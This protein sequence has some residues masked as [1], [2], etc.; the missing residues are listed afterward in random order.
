VIL[1]KG[2]AQFINALGPGMRVGV[3]LFRGFA[4]AVNGLLTATGNTIGWLDN[5]L[6]INLHS[7]AQDFDTARHAIASAWDAL[8]RD[9]I[10]VAVTNIVG[11]GSNLKRWYDYTVGIFTSLYH[12]GLT[13][14]NN[15]WA[16]IKT[17]TTTGINAV[18]GFF[19]AMPGKVTSALGSLG[20]DLKNLGSAATHELLSGITSVATSILNWFKSFGSSI[21]S[22]FKKV[23][24]IFSPSSVFHSIGVSIA[25]GLAN[26]I[27]AGVSKHV[28][29]AMGGLH[30][31]VHGSGATAQAYAQSI[32][33]RFGWAGQWPALNAVAMAE[34]GWSLTARNPSS[35]AYGIAQFINGPG[36]YYQYGGNPNTVAGQVTA[37]FNYIRQRYGSPD[38]AWAHES[39]Y[40]WYGQGLQNG[41]FSKPTIIGVGESGPEMVNITPMRS[42][43]ANYAATSGDTYVLNVTAPPLTDPDEVYRT[44]WKGLRDL[45]RHRKMDLGLT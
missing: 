5:R 12:S 44:V 10:G 23:L 13:I 14:W 45:K 35:G 9:V 25:H 6:S 18:T 22:A 42:R 11:I 1:V 15:T 7:W 20:T 24:G 26:G 37:F 29:P 40:H 43:A 2:V 19:R 32:L 38:A 4:D 21:A 27:H 17:L 41:L 34:S 36:E 28:M 31:A 8:W 3:T 16:G 33:G 30:G 39:R